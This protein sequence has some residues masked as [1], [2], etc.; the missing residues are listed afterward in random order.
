MKGSIT[1]NKKTGKWDIAIDI[2]ND[3]STG[4]RKQKRKRGFS[5]K[6]EAEIA[7]TRLNG[8]L[9]EGTYIDPSKKKLNEFMEEWFETRRMQVSR[10]TLI[11]QLSLFNHHIKPHIGFSRLNE[12]NPSVIQKLITTL[13]KNAN[14]QPSS[15]SKIIAILKVA[16]EKAV[17]LQLIKVNPVTNVDLPRENKTEMIV[18]DKSQVD[19]FL[20]NSKKFRHYTACLIAVY[21]GMRKGEILGL[22]WKD[23]DLEKK[24]IYIRQTL[25]SDG[26]A[27]KAGAKNTSSVRTIHISNQLIS[28]LKVHRKKL[29]EE[30][31]KNGTPYNDLDLVICTKYGNPIDP[32]TL[33]RRF[34]EQAKVIGLPVIR[35]HDL[36][37]THAT[38]LIEQNVNVK[39]ISERLGH[40]SIQMT[41]DRY[42]HVLPSMQQDVAKQLDNLFKSL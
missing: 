9:I 13:V 32:P 29:T 14:L 7:L 1:K 26:K 23:L 31:L 18:W 11:N 2:G 25:E 36:R 21:T 20:S 33:S 42:S 28:Q 3:P 34:K 38:L 15:I 30:R 4:K 6:K 12:I 10:R 41:L 5:T 17:K 27:F 40:S 19:T 22:R 24:V 37:H 8:D 39:I 35:F 16:L